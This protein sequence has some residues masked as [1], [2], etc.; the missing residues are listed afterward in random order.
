MPICPACHIIYGL[1][2]EK[3]PGCGAPRQERP[4]ESTTGI[5]P[6]RWPRNSVDRWR[7][8]PIQMICL[9]FAQTFCVILIVVV[10]ISTVQE[11]IMGKW[12]SAVL[13]IALW[14]PVTYGFYTAMKLAIQ[15]ARNE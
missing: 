5:N 10:M 13:H 14:L 11:L 2:E 1:N 7:C 9:H 3:C 12:P 15:Y 8:S 6:S 4:L